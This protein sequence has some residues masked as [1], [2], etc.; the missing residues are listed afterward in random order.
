MIKRKKYN[1][2]IIITNGGNNGEYFI[3]KAREIIG[4]NTIACCSAYA[5]ENHINWVKNMENVLILKGLDFHKK[6]FKCVK[7]NDE[8]LYNELCREMNN[9]YN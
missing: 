5:V 4:S 1:K 9:T 7:Y 2:I 3:K 8:S 6:F